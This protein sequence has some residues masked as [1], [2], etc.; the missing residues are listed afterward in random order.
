[1]FGA[2]PALGRII[3]RCYDAETCNDDT[4]ACRTLRGDRSGLSPGHVEQ[5]LQMLQ[6]VLFCVGAES[7]E[8]TQAG[9]RYLVGEI[10]ATHRPEP[11]VD[12]PPHVCRFVCSR[13][14]A[15]RIEW[16]R[17]DLNPR[18]ADISGLCASV[19]QRVIS[20]GGDQP[21]A[22]YISWSVVT[23]HSTSGVSR[24]PGLGHEPSCFLCRFDLKG[25]RFP[26]LPP[27][28]F[29][30]ITRLALPAGHELQC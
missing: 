4:D 13:S 25:F 21:A 11:S 15:D 23:G 9:Q 19:L 6:H 12:N 28:G 18:S 5:C 7:C 30:P 1:M 26:G 27:V 2:E 3:T 24:L 20:A 22:Q 17:R 16:A 10:D 14:F 29:V 8:L